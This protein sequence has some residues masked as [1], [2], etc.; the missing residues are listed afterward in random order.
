MV[1]ATGK[2]YFKK[3]ADNQDVWIETGQFSCSVATCWELQSIVKGMPLIRPLDRLLLRDEGHYRALL[4]K[5]I[6][7]MMVTHIP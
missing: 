2:A 3:A 1:G 6:S 4:R 5:M 7:R